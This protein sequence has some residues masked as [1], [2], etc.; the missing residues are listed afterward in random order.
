MEGK[1]HGRKKPVK[2][3]QRALVDKVLARYP[4]DFTVF[5]ELLQNGDDAKATEV[6]IEFQTS[7]Y[8]EHS[9]GANDNANEINDTIPNLELF[10]WV[11]RNNGEHFKPSDWDRLTTIGDGNPDVQKIGAFGVGFYSVFSVTDS[12]LVISGG[13]SLSISFEENQLYT[14]DDTCPNSEWT[15]IEMKLKEDMRG[16]V[17][18]PFDL[19]RFLAATMTFMSRVETTSVFF[20]G[21]AFLKLAKFREVPTGIALPSDMRP[22]SAKGTMGIKTVSVVPQ[23][24][25]VKVTDLALAAGTKIPPAQHAGMENLADVSAKSEASMVAPPSRASTLDHPS[26]LTYTARYFVYSA[27]VLISASDDLRNGLHAMTKKSPP[28]RFDFE[29]V[30]FSKEEYDAIAAEE[31]RNPIL[32]SVFRGPQ[33]LLPLLNGQYTSR[34]FIGQSTAQTTGIGG[35]LSGR[36]IPTVERGSIDLTNGHIAKWNEE[37]L[38]V[39]GFL[40]RLVYEREIKKIQRAWPEGALTD[41]QAAASLK[42]EATYIMQY[43]TFHTSTPD[44]KVSKILEDGFF[45]CSKSVSFPILSNS[46]IRDT[47]DVRQPDEKFSSFMKVRP[48][49][50]RT[51]PG[52]PPSLIG[53]LPNQ[54]VVRQYML[55]DVVGELQGRTLQDDEMVGLLRWWVDVYET[56]TNHGKTLSELKE[57]TKSY[58]RTPKREM[59]LV[60]I[61]KFV[62]SNIIGPQLRPD[63]AL[64]PDTIPWSFTRALAQGKITPALSWEP[65]TVVDWLTYLI[66]PQVDSAHDI[67]KNAEYSNRVVF[68]LANIWGMLSD[69]LKSEAQELME[70]VAWIATNKGLQRGSEAYF[71]EADVFRDLP[72]I[73]ANLFDPQVAT[74]LA[75]FGVRKQLDFYDLLAKAEKS[76]TWS[77]VEM[78]NYF[79]SDPRTEGLIEVPNMVLVFQIVPRHLQL[80]VPDRWL[81]KLGFLRYPPLQD[82]IRIAGSPDAA[83]RRA[84]FKYLSDKFDELYGVDYQPTNYKD[85]QFIPAIKDGKGCVGTHEEVYKDS[86]WAMMGFQIVCSSVERKII[87]RLRIRD[88]PSAEQVI[89]VFRERP[90]KDFSTATE[91]FAFLATKQVLSPGDL[92]QIAYIPIVPVEEPTS[93]DGPRLV[94]PRACFLGGSQY[95]EE[96]LH[97]RIFTFVDFGERANKFLEACRVKTKP[98]CSDIVNVL[99]KDPLDFLK[100]T[101][102]GG[103]EDLE[104]YV[105]LYRIVSLLIVN[106]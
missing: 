20:D 68:I 19:A 47:K 97:R 80:T 44:A 29:M 10:K 84:A 8:A 12:P 13:K 79:I 95:P 4:E 106:T 56:V 3:N 93:Q 70:D 37:L 41:S 15:S 17:P 40:A 88:A 53:S 62:D 61:F 21:R 11:V 9:V 77:A 67:R 42:D 39:G 94:P 52:D 66:S 49:L 32:G 55:A 73:T 6:R 99:I 31:K 81:T 85:M 30:Y 103:K 98:D 5:R 57:A 91:W 18:N 33:G 26:W 2:V 46:G 43:F 101:N 90:P 38:Y 71:Q 72:V 96:H 75:E 59:S 102:P 74:V 24:I 92:Q 14:L 48:I 64:P 65:M 89:E 60:N 87:E 54:Y 82:L 63:D 83:V 58:S 22:T 100:K 34:I 27:E 28:P 7:D 25:T 104:K 45:R 69:E 78:I 76:H 51:V 86:S 36:F 105:I 23:G 50:L 1:D 16:P 35:H